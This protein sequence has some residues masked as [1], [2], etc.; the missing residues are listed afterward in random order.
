ML[1]LTV[2]AINNPFG[3]IH[4]NP[5]DSEVGTARVRSIGGGAQVFTRV[6]R[7]VEFMRLH[8]D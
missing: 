6:K 2:Q 1:G 7:G 3:K 4:I 8:N 5:L